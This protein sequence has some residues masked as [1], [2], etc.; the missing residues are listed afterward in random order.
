M[1][2]GLPGSSGALLSAAALAT[3]CGETWKRRSESRLRN[4][5]S[6]GLNGWPKS[7]SQR[8]VTLLQSQDRAALGGA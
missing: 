8:T 5:F 3:F 4:S 6:R 7:C 1:T 2:W